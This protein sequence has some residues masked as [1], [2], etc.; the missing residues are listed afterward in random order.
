MLHLVPMAISKVVKG[1][2]GVICDIVSYL[3]NEMA[4]GGEYSCFLILL[5]LRYQF[6]REKF[7]D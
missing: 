4:G 5:Q 3:F 6:S 2:G 1:D 7:N